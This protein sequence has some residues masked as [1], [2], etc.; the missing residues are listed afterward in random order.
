VWFHSCG[1]ITEALPHWIDI[2]LDVISNLQTLALDLPAIAERFGRQI[3][4]FG[5][6]DVQ[7]NIVHGDRESIHREIRQLFEMFD[8]R[9]GMYMASPCNSIMP[10]TPIENVW[11]M[12]E[13]IEAYGTFDR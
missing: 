6:I 7:E 12:M 1:N 3:T 13:A 2:H 11:H 10:E 8:A 4:F 9:N 5:G